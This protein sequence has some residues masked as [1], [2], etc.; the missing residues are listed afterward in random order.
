MEP[1]PES[2]RTCNSKESFN[3]EA[4]LVLES[5]FIFSLAMMYHHNGRVGI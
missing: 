5:V 2:E 4:R 1:S 3:V